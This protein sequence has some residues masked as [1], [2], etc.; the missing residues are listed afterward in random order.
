MAQSAINGEDIEDSKNELAEEVDQDKDHDEGELWELLN[1]H[2]QRKWPDD[3]TAE[4]LDEF[5]SWVVWRVMIVSIHFRFKLFLVDLCNSNY[6]NSELEISMTVLIS[7]L[8]FLFS[9]AFLR[10]ILL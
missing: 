5:D 3:K 6:L 9:F 8:T 4:P 1:W 10:L 7:W 2:D